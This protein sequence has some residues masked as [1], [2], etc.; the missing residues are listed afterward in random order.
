MSGN[1]SILKRVCEAMMRQNNL[2]SNSTE[3]VRVLLAI[4]IIL[5]P[6][7]LSLPAIP[8]SV[9]AKKYLSASTA[10]S[11]LFNNS[12]LVSLTS[13]KINDKEEVEKKIDSIEGTVTQVAKGAFLEENIQSRDRVKRGREEEEVKS[14]LIDEDIIRKRLKS[15]D[16]KPL[17]MNATI[18]VA[19]GKQSNS[20]KKVIRGNEEEDDDEDDDSLPDID[21]QAD[22]DK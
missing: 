10:S 5:S 15:D 19:F 7:S 22:P 14:D 4:E 3:A 9:A 12:N 16:I 6:S 21:I 20:D 8:A 18:G 11:L 13:Q 2:N 1:I 17:V